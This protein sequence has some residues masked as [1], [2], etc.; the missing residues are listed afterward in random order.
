M[1]HD[2]AGGGEETHDLARS[3]GADTVTIVSMHEELHMHMHLHPHWTTCVPA[4][5]NPAL[6]VRYRE[7]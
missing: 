3:H 4:W 7:S 1:I 2:T 6:R 5:Q